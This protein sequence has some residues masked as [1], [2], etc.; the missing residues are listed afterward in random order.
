MGA[1]GARALVPSAITYETKINS[2][3]VQGKRTRAGAQQDSVAAEGGAS[4]A[5]EA[6]GDGGRQHM[7]NRAAVLARIPVQIQVPAESR[8]DVSVHGLW[9]RGTTAMFGVRIVNLDAGSYLRMKP[10]NGYCK[11]GEIKE[12]PVHSGLN[13]S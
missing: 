8:A 6:Q 10:E 11:C 12:R 9:K 7:V 5:G 4:I 1:L 13:E 3:K 2:R